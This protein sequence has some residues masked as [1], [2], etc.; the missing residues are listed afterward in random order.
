[1]HIFCPNQQCKSDE[2]IDLALKPVVTVVSAAI[3]LF[4]L[5]TVSYKTIQATRVNC[6]SFKDWVSAQKTFADH[7]WLHRSLDRDHD[8][9][10]CEKLLEKNIK[11]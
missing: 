3:I 9:I 2:I 1:M 11:Q 8:G 7:T 5:A 4:L 6:D 10:A